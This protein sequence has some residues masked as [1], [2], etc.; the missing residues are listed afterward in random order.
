MLNG[1]KTF[2]HKQN[3]IIMNILIINHYAGSPKMGM[4]YRPYY[5]AQEWI[6][7]GH[8]VSILLANNSHIRQFNPE[9]TDTIREEFIDGIKYIWVKTPTYKGNGVGRIKN[10]FAFIKTGLSK[11]RYLADTLK[12][13]VVIASSTYTSDNYV[14]RKI[15]KL[16]N[17]KYLYEV[18]DLWPL[19]PMELG[20]MPKYHPFIVLMQHGENFG[21]RKADAV[22]SMLPKTKEHMS[23]HGLDL[24]NWYYIP[25]GIVLSEW[26]ELAEL[27][28]HTKTQIL[29]IKSTFKTT[30]AYTGTLGLANALDSFV[31][32]AEKE[33]DV[34]F[35]MVGKG[36]EKER[37][38][39]LI[40]DK[41]LTN[42]FI[43]ESINK[44]E[45]PSLL[46]MF[47]ILYIGLQSQSLFRFGISPNKLNDYMMAAKPIIQ[48]IDA[49]NN[50][51]K[52][53]GCGIYVEPENPSAIVEA[54]DQLKLTSKE[55][56]EIMGQKGR[57][58]VLKNHDYK[59]LAQQ[60]IQ[61][62]EGI[63]KS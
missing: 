50:V 61:V 27:N 9:Q 60:F 59:I 18:H 38:Q 35:I 7:K 51:V 63:S 54:I 56:L 36:P 28:E 4:A 37:L 39:N 16:A 26:E 49:G 8:E 1:E 5:L 17:A 48:A 2:S 46:L 45:I 58:F 23:A 30:I 21:Y 6:K 3:K 34:A 44:Q 31:L 52:E 13:N 10:M 57:D 40:K 32:A 25:N 24:N 15:A 14:A 29:G 22:I 55:D 11:A 33:R 53:V 42:V 43:L 20:G 12:P 47:D 19:S 62:I 41:S